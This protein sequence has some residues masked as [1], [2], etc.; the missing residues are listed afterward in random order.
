VNDPR[1]RKPRRT[2]VQE[3]LLTQLGYAAI[4]GAVALA[5][6]WFG[7][8]WIARDNMADRA[9]KWAEDLDYL[10]AGLYLEGDTERYLRIEGYVSKFPE[11][12]FVRYYDAQG[13]MFHVEA[14]DNLMPDAVLLSPEQLAELAAIARDE[15]SYRL[16]RDP[17]SSLTGISTA[18]LSESIRSDG[19][20]DSMSLDELQTTSQV[21]GY[22][23]LGLNYGDY[24]D[25]PIASVGRA[26]SAVALAFLVLE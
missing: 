20:L 11:I 15:T 24:Y 26:S 1:E 19:L 8:N 3:I 13:D 17:E 4:V 22:V 2:L 25:Q 5:C 16:R 10:G 7:S 14:R 23:E 6:L 21:I 9:I 18:I 12:Q